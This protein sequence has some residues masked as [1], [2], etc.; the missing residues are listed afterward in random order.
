[1]DGTNNNFATN[2]VGTTLLSLRTVAA[3]TFKTAFESL[4]SKY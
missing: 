2:L 3:N 1:M 4:N